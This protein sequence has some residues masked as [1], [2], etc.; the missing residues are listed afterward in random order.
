MSRSAEALINPEL[1]AWARE[2]AGMALDEAAER[3]HLRA[4]QLRS[5]EEGISRPT[6]NQLRELARVYRRPVTVFYLPKP[7]KDFD[8]M[9]DFR[10]RPGG[11]LLHQSPELHFEI[12]R[13]Q[14]R[15][16]VAIE[17]CQLLDEPVPKFT[18][19]ARVG[20]DPEGTAHRIRQLLGVGHGEQAAW[21]TAYQAFNRWRAA[22]E[23]AG[24]LVFQARSVEPDEARAF[25]I[26]DTPFP[27][28]VLNVKDRAPQAR[29]FSL[30]HEFAHIA[31][32]QGGV[33]DLAEEHAE[34]AEIFC[35]RVAGAVLVPRDQLLRERLVADKAR[36][37]VWA[38]KDINDLAHRYWVSREVV[39]RRLLIFGRVSAPFY[40]AKADQYR[41][42]F[43]AASEKGGRGFMP[44][45]L[46]PIVTGG[47]RFVTLVLRSYHEDKVTPSDVADFLEVRLKHLPSIEREFFSPMAGLRVAP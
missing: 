23:R 39:L 13:A 11:V 9:R 4:D 5:W 36:G 44:P 16:Q 41:R 37:G 6:M 45:H 24:A 14:A 17:L 25:S 46:T 43:R 19:A 21:G 35:N 28:V 42:E 26:S 27:A 22:V 30:L 1:L 12:R 47:H 20:D 18:F 38:D 2:S 8:A 29:I 10:R 15:R 31:L 33:C 3:S 34:P 32:R 40:R 7:P